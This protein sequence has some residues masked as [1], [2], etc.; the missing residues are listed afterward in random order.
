MGTHPIFESDFD[1][2]TDWKRRLSILHSFFLFFGNSRTNYTKRTGDGIGRERENLECRI[3]ERTN[4]EQEMPEPH[5]C[6]M[7]N[8]SWSSLA[9][10]EWERRVLWID[11]SKTLPNSGRVS[12]RRWESTSRSKP[13]SWTENGSS[14]RFGTRQVKRSSIQSPLLITGVRA[15][16]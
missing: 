2:L 3:G 12:I 8:F 10:R 6:Q 5:P 4:D 11:S 15:V 14:C 13:S 7:S 9:T 1:C 16:R